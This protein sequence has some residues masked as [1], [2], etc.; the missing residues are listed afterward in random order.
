MD[1]GEGLRWEGGKVHFVVSGWAE[2]HHVEGRFCNGCQGEVEVWGG[3][4]RMHRGHAAEFIGA[5]IEL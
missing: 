2:S 1:S 5:W 4:F 3:V